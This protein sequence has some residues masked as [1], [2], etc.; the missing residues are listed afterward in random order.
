MDFDINGRIRQL[1]KH[2]DLTQQE[3]ADKIGL[4]QNSVALIEAGKRN[5]SVRTTLAICRAFGVSDDWLMLG[6]GDIFE[7][8]PRAEEM[9]RYI[10]SL[11][12][13]DD[14]IAQSAIMAILKAY[15]KLDEPSKEIIRQSI[16]EMAESIK[17]KEKTAG[18]NTL[19]ELLS[20]PDEF[21]EN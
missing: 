20:E 8:L 6:K 14:T 2:L 21:E 12:Q 13:S 19:E 16:K 18:R 10:D 1:R 17:Y 4:K 9:Q 11:F 3:F 5:P 7:P 15:C